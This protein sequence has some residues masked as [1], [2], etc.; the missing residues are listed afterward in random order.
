MQLPQHGLLPPPR[1]LFTA[2][3]PTNPTAMPLPSADLGGVPLVS[4][5]APDHP[6]WVK[7]RD[8]NNYQLLFPFSAYR[9]T[10]LQSCLLSKLSYLEVRIHYSVL[11]LWPIH[12]SLQLPSGDGCGPEVEFKMNFALVT[13]S[14]AHNI[15][16]GHR[17]SRKSIE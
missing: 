5:P 12:C 10:F 4:T 1:C 15:T 14:Q 13:S 7:N 3:K 8:G 6:T 17:R 11:D 9:K 16:T 2:H